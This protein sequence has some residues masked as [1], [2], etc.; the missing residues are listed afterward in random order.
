MCFGLVWFG[1]VCG[2]GFER[3]RAFE[4]LYLPGLSGEL[5]WRLSNRV[6]ILLGENG[7][8][9]ERTRMFLG[10]AY[11]LRSQ[12]VHG[13]EIKSII[14]DGQN[15]KLQKLVNEIEEFLRQSLKL[16]ISLS[17]RYDQKSIIK[18]IDESLVNVKSRRKILNIV[19]KA[20]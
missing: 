1:C 14:I 13:E 9:A 7:E 20:T 16:F 17:K 3:A 8:S 5:K 19:K 6:A 10:K 11:I 18:I 15:I 4:A 2:V 12:I